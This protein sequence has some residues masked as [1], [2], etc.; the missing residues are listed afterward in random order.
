MVLPNPNLSPE[1]SYNT[2]LRLGRELSYKGK[3]ELVGFYTYLVDAMVRRKASFN[4][5]DS[6]LYDGELSEV[7]MLTNSG[8]AHI[9]GA[10][11]NLKANVTKRIGFIQTFTWTDGK[12]LEDNVPLRHVAPAFGRTSIFFRSDKLKAAIGCDVTSVS[13]TSWGFPAHSESRALVFPMLYDSPVLFRVRI[14]ESRVIYEC[15]VKGLAVNTGF[16]LK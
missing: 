14:V 15:D 4:G 10:S 2:E 3:I 8:R 6:I 11:L 7:Q 16:G 9:Y 12:D 13:G 1:Y 5:Q